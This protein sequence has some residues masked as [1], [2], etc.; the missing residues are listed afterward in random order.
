MSARLSDAFTNAL[1]V[2]TSGMQKREIIAFTKTVDGWYR[3]WSRAWWMDNGIFF[4][5]TIFIVA[6]QLG[7]IFGAISLWSRGEIQVGTFVL[8]ISYLTIF[9]DQ[10]VEIN[11]MYR[12]L[13][14]TAGDMTEAIDMLRAPL[15]ITDSDDA[16]ILSVK[17]GA[18]VFEQVNFA[19]KTDGSEVLKDFSLTIH[20]GEKIGLVGLSGSGKSTILKL[21]FR[22]YDI[23]DG[24]ITIDNLDIRSVT[25]ES[26]RQSM[27]MVPQ[28]PVLFHRTIGENIS[29][30]AQEEQT[31]SA[32]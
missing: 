12:N 22:L 18:I 28:D 26:L 2:I 16:Q 10:V 15:T 5:S 20:P 3:V 31:Q 13:F 14:R 32:K 4:V 1:T 19:Y 9:I 7:T 30:A 27:S 29:Y 23:N 11:F 6:L 21:L 8:L 24:S 25:Q 17:K